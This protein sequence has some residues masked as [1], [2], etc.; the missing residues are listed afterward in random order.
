MTDTTAPP[1]SVTPPSQ[2]EVP[3]NPD[4]TQ[5]PT[6]IGGQA[7]DRP[8]NDADIQRQSGRPQSRR[9][10]IQAAFDKAVSQQEA[11]EKPARA[12]PKS[13]PKAREA[14]AGDNQP[15]EETEKLD[16]KKR[17]SDQPRG[18]RGQ[19]APRQ[20]AETRARTAAQTAPGALP[21]P[22]ERPDAVPH[23]R[24]PEGVPYR[25]PPPRMAP[26]AQAEWHAAPESVRGEVYRMHQ[27]FGQA[28]QAYR[29]DAEAMNEI[30][31]FQRLAH[32]QGTTLKAA[33]TN[34]VSMEYKLRGNLLAGLDQIIHNLNIPGQNGQRITLRDVAYHVLS[35]SPEQLQQVQQGNAQQAAQ[36]Q[37]GALHQE[38]AG[39][40]NYLHQVHNQQQ[41]TYTRA[42]VDQFADD[43]NHPRFDELAAVIHAEVAHGYSL[44]DA[45]RRAE[46]LYPGTHAAQTRTQSAQT[47]DSDRSISGAPA[48]TSGQPEGKRRSE[49]PVGRREAIGNA[50]RRVNGSL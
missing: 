34:Y 33:L 31:E 46:R 4:Q 27:E 35:S 21:K 7:P 44:E 30:R 37:I 12:P 38:V 14:K 13:A 1:A 20:T 49:K 36:H 40:K 48:S 18:E 42:Q 19:F 15:P 3:I 11:K 29:A 39:L 32:E 23:K 28:H 47:R 22:P 8:V 17:P 9:E 41:F 5:A 43:G 24:L 26:H 50:I 2:S 6:P 25:D 16:L 10:A 45:Y